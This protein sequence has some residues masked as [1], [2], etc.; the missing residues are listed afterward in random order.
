MLAGNMAAP[1]ALPVVDPSALDALREVGVGNSVELSLGGRVD[2]GAG[3]PAR[4]RGRLMAFSEGIAIADTPMG[5]MSFGPTALV[6]AG[7][8]RIVVLKERS[9]AVA[10][11]QLYQS[12]GVVI[13][14]LRAV[15]V[16]TA[17]NFQ[18]YDQWRTGLVRPDTPGQTRSNLKEL[19]YA[20]L[21]RPIWPF[22][23]VPD[24]KPAPLVVET[25]AAARDSL[26]H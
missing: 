2:T 18:A 9:Y 11:P 15:V 19:A 3:G 13:D 17:G 12:L 23:E 10:F 25:P 7:A 5:A 21:P 24:W 16:K 6:E 22:D 14:D 26:R 1:V 20:S 8:L 4:V